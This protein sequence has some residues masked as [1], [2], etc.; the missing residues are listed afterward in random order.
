MQV[1]ED[2]RKATGHHIQTL[3]GRKRYLPDIAAI[4]KDATSLRSKAERKAVNTM[5]QGSAADIAKLAMIRLHALLQ[6]PKWRGHAVMVLMVHDELVFEVAAS[7]ASELAAAVRSV[8]ERVV[9]LHVPMPVKVSVG[10][11]WGEMQE[12]RP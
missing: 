8:M 5:C 4:G 10:P 11:S 9:R 1:L 6:T 3:L 12:L 2:C 7:R